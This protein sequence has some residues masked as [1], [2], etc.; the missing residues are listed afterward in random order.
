MTGTVVTL[1]GAIGTRR[2]D[3]AVALAERLHWPR[4]KFSDYIKSR[5]EG[6]G[7]TSEDRRMLQK[8]GQELVQTDVESF[9]LGVLA[10]AEEWKAGDDLVVDGLR[11][12]EVRLALLNAIKPSTL[13]YVHVEVDEAT[14]QSTAENV[15]GIQERLLYRY[16]QDLTE[17]QLP[18]I[19]PAYAD[20][21]VDGSLP[22]GMVAEKIVARLRTMGRVA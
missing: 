21:I 8:V 22:A 1:S 4:V 10:Q 11:H 2:S 6:A 19:L 15:R 12:T 7:G 9:V 17:A 20:Q 5:L 14:R 16:D 13:Y 18:K 3:I